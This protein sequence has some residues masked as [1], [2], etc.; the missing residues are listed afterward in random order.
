LY[1]HIPFCERK[2]LYCDFYSVEG[3]DLIEDFLAVL[4]REIALRAPEQ[5]GTA[6][7]TI[8]FGGGTPS[9]LTPRQLEW[10]LS[11]L[12]A[13]FQI[14]TDA[15]I[16][17]EANPGTVHKE[18]LRAFRSLGVNRLSIGIQSFRGGDLDVLGRVHNAADAFRC[19]DLSRTAGFDNLGV[20]LIYSIPGQTLEHWEE[21][22][23][24]A[25]DLAPQH[26]AAYSLIVEE[27]TPL[28]H[29]V[30][31]GTV[32]THSTDDEARMYERTMEA[33]AAHGYE[34]YEV[35]NYA[36]PGFRCRHNAAYWSHQDYLGLGPSAHSFRTEAG[37]KVGERCWNVADL[38]RYRERLQGNSLPVA[39][40]ERI[41]TRGLVGERIFLGF[42]SSGLDLAGLAADLGY[43]LATR[44]RETL[45]WMSDA[46]L[47]GMRGNILRLT[48]KGYLL[49]DEICRRVLQDVQ[50]C[51]GWSAVDDGDRRVKPL[52][53][54]NLTGEIP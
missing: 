54:N 47:V 48:A 13:A 21:N 50:T 39:G 19:I 18:S 6:F 35:S 52:S 44:Q 5:G 22:L 9:L 43:D 8:F 33:C 1:V 15:E 28:A 2:C 27:H 10:I 14:A 29:M 20:D 7:Q 53:K 51:P 31:T 12:R 3:P 30:R 49:C 42:R 40:R 4:A 11:R 41:G 16:T 32:R 45:G 34:H 25:A 37:G 36:L 23:R 38:S 26:L 24:I 46:G 17:L